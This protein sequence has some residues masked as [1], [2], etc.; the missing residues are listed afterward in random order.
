ML[1][2]MRLLA[3]WLMKRAIKKNQVFHITGR[4]K[5]DIDVYMIR[6]VV[7]KTRWF[8][9]YLHRFLRS[10]DD[11]YHDHPWPFFT[12]ILEGGYKDNILRKDFYA[13]N[14]RYYW[15]TTTVS[16]KPGDLLFRKAEHIHRVILDKHLTLDTAD[17]GPL[18]F[19][20]L[21]K[22]KREWGFWSPAPHSA[23]WAWTHWRKF[24]NIPE[25]PNK[26]NV[27]MG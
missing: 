16:A 8:G 6:Y 10:D 12:Y 20:V 21:G 11:T 2:L 5:N 3:A 26:E 15:I 9:I 1:K 19:V 27:G 14:T 18:T 13:K 23:E 25:G 24:L 22:K 7:A 17:Q 4:E